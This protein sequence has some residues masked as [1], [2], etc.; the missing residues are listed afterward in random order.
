MEFFATCP[1]SFEQLLAAELTRI[2]CKQVRPLK[3][4]VSFAGNL[5]E[6]L[7][8]C[9]WS[10][11]AS[12]VILVISRFD[13]A[14]ADALYEGVAAVA[15]EEH[16][17]SGATFSVDAHGTNENLRNSQYASMRAKD[18]IVDRMH[19]RTGTRPQVNVEHPDVPIALRISREKATLGLAL[20]GSEPLFRR[21]Y[22]S[23]PSARSPIAPLR[24]DYAAALL[25]LGG[26]PAL[27]ETD[28]PCLVTLFGGAGTVAAE[29]LAEAQH[30]APGLLRTRWGFERWHGIDA[31]CWSR[32][33]KRAQ[34]AAEKGADKMPR[35]ISCD[36]RR[37]HDGATRQLLRSAGLPTSVTFVR[38]EGLADALPSETLL[39]CDLSWVGANALP[40]EVAGL[41]L[42][43]GTAS[44]LGAGKAVVLAHGTSADAAMG[45]APTET[46]DL[47]IGRDEERAAAYDLAE[48]QGS[49]FVTLQGGERV[50]VLVPA[51]D[52]FVRRLEK[53]ATERAKWAESEDVTCY[54]VYD[55]DLPDYAV[56]IDLYQGCDTPGRWLQVS[57]YAAPHDI[58]E[59][60]AHKRLLDVLAI[61]PRVMGVEPRNV[62]LRVRTRSRGGSQYADQGDGLAK[63]NRRPRDG[64]IELPMGA[65]LVD[66][67]GLTF[68]VNFSERLDCGIFLDHRDTRGMIREMAKR[69]QGGR[70]FLNLFA[71]TGTAT[72]YAAD[73]GAAE[74]TTVDL[75]GA[76]LAWARRNMA[77]NGFDGPEH[78]FVRADVIGWIAEQRKTRNRW[79][80]V[81]CDVPTFSNSKDMR[82]SSFDVQRDHAELIIGV[83]R[84]LARDGV[85]IFSC[86]LRTFKPDIEKLTRAGVALEDITAQT[87]P[88]DFARNPHVH[89]CYLVRRIPREEM[90][91]RPEAGREGSKPRDGKPGGFRRGG[92]GPRDGKPG[93][94]RRDGSER[95]GDGKPGGF[96]RDGSGPRD[97]KPGGFR[98][99]GSGPRDG[100]PGGFKRGG[101]GPR[102]NGPSPK[103]DQ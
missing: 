89:Y 85:G 14:D 50:Q 57:E 98:R 5:E 84:L 78:A 34:K 46:L 83:S 71:Y 56:T 64:R 74:T 80:L 86:N 59:T 20:S 40:S 19:A 93:G 29:A 32:L 95:R 94:F 35:I 51:S 12:R 47:I 24:P 41:G 27:C 43:S 52:Q 26:W 96:K 36:S 66:E 68:E 25:E 72:C 82:K 23:A 61:A 54:R 9:L 55:A 17:P 70:R 77:R 65:H 16:L 39:T 67:G 1:A 45:C 102:R 87:I 99:G 60:L 91:E 3:G 76:S 79:D 97:G 18:A 90:P 13:A 37:N 88:A 30:R 31:S 21:G 8:A 2:G 10:R 22:E 81:F 28:D 38:P 44:A 7:K 58:D 63:G 100:K 75:S 15:W 49:P 42:L 11:L 48:A 73:G 6:A 69:M 101:S 92:S 53:V 103:R 33:V 62:Y 4:Q